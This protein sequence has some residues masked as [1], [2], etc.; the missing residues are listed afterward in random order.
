M[1]I[2]QSTEKSFFIRDII[3]EETEQQEKKVAVGMDKEEKNEI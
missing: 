3:N 1:I 2:I